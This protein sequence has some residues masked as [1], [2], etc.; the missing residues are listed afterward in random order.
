MET[1]AER[2]LKLVETCAKGNMSTFARAVNVS[3]AYI[4][5]LKLH[6]ELVPTDRVLDDICAAYNVN[7]DWLLTGTG[8][9]HPPK[10]RGAQ[11]GEIAAAA[12]KADP[13]EA[14]RFFTELLAG[15]TDGEIL[16]MYEIF[17]RWQGEK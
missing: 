10:T 8:D 6:P 2:I 3:P 9:Q 13:E 16:L 11:I 1:I 5:K 15:K 14:R 7:K 12:G 17:K 4:S